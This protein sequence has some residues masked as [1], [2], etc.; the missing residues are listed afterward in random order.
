MLLKKCPLRAR[1]MQIEF[2][3][4]SGDGGVVGASCHRI[5]RAFGQRG[6]CWCSSAFKLQRATV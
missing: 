3:G 2:A 4:A 6:G 5:P 1:G